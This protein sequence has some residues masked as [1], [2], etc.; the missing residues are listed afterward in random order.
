MLR[1]LAYFSHCNNKICGECHE[2]LEWKV[3]V[4]D[5]NTS[6]PIYSLNKST[7]D[8]EKQSELTE[9]HLVYD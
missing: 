4:K 3:D 8:A 7:V 6:A 2:V 1:R 5:W 9:N